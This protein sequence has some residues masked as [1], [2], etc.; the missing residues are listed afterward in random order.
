MRRCAHVTKPSL[1]T[2][3]YRARISSMFPTDSNLK[4]WFDT[5]SFCYGNLHQISYAIYIK[6]L[7]RILGK[8]FFFNVFWK[9]FTFCIFST[10]AKN[11]LCQVVG[12][13]AKELCNLGN[14][15][16]S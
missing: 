5:S 12:A 13:K 4:I 2:K 16:C 8:N 7:E 10:K 9:K 15:I 3:L 1:V 11:S 6:G 14:L